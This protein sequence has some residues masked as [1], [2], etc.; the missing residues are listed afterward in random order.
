MIWLKCRMLTTLKGELRLLGGILGWNTGAYD[1]LDMVCTW[2]HTS[3]ASM[4]PYCVLVPAQI[5]MTWSLNVQ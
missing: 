2:V 3:T 4:A 5:L 1:M